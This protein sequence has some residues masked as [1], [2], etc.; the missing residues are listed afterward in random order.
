MSENKTTNEQP[1]MSFF[2]IASEFESLSFELENMESLLNIVITEVFSKAVLKDGSFVGFGRYEMS[3]GNI[4]EA[5]CEKM[6]NKSAEIY[7]LAG[8]FYKK[9]KEE[10]EIK[11]VA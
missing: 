10:P 3:F 11:T 9:S 7:Q 8:M 4:I 6:R 2:D 5:V 1:E